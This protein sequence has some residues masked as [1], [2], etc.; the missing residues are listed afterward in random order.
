MAFMPDPWE[1]SRCFRWLTV[2]HDV[3]RDALGIEVDFSLPAE[4]VIRR[5]NQIM[6]WR[7]QPVA[8]RSDNGPEYL[9]GLLQ[10]WADKN[11]T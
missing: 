4:R 8:I 7:G 5:L 10:D 11:G 3:N 2:I 1:G 9:S 6:E